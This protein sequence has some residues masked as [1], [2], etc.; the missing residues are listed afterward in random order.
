MTT[1][2]VGEAVRKQALS[3]IVGENVNWYNPSEGQF[4]NIFWEVIPSWL[5]GIELVECALC[6]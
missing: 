6:Y 3:Y 2:F 5:L 1:H 4:G